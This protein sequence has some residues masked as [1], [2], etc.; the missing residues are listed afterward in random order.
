MIKLLRKQPIIRIANTDYGDPMSSKNHPRDAERLERLTEE[1]GLDSAKWSKQCLVPYP[2][3]VDQEIDKL[4]DAV[5]QFKSGDQKL[6]ISTLVSMRERDMTEH[7]K[8]VGQWSGNFRQKILDIPNSKTIPEGKRVTPNI[9]MALQQEVIQR[10]GHRCRYCQIRVIHKKEIV[11]LQSM[12]GRKLIPLNRDGKYA[13]EYRHGIINMCQ[14]TFDHVTPRQQGGQ[15][16]MSNLVTS[17]KSCNYGK[18]A[19][20]LKQLGLNLPIPSK[21]NDQKW[22]GLTDLLT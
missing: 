15:N 11:K 6:A 19:K 8:N 17:C 4:V 10:D 9:P 5:K 21:Q 7:Y 20:T 22:A 13:V 16:T 3:W 2:K 18:G 12:F 14:A 1:I